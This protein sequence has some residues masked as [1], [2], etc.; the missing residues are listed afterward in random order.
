MIASSGF[1]LAMENHTLIKI[2]NVSK[3]FGHARDITGR[4][5]PKQNPDA[6][7][8]RGISYRRLRAQR[9]ARKTFSHPD[10]TV[11]VGIGPTRALSFDAARGL[12]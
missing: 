2:E 3:H 1:L 5:R 11:G 6:V 8:H 10:Y 4:N 7:R 12:G 9:Y